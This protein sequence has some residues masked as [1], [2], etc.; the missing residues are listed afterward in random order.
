[1]TKHTWYGHGEDHAPS[2]ACDNCRCDAERRELR[3][4]L[5]KVLERYDMA[6]GDGGTALPDDEEITRARGLLAHA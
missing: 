1:M 3:D 4:A 2:C 5:R 6:N